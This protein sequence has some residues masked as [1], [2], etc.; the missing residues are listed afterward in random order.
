MPKV[1]CKTCGAKVPAPGMYCSAGMDLICQGRAPVA[2][3][4]AVLTPGE[5]HWYGSSCERCE[6]EWSER[7]EAWRQGAQDTDLDAM[8]SVPARVTH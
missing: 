8:F 5:R 7:I 1:T 4:G 2:A 3:C 6:K